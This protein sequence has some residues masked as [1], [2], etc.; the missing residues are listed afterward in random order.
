LEKAKVENEELRKQRVA[1]ALSLT[2][3]NNN[4]EIGHSLKKLMFKIF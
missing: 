2:H 3:P 1:D 4:Q